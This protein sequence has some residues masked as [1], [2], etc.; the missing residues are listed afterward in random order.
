MIIEDKQLSLPFSTLTRPPHSVGGLRQRMSRK[1][2]IERLKKL[3]ASREARKKA[4]KEDQAAAASSD[5]NS[6]ARNPCDPSHNLA[7]YYLK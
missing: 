3:L 2:Q 4:A 7:K 5:L 6:A 1:K